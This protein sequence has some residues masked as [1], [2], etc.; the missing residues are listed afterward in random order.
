MRNSL[1]L[2][3]IIVCRNSIQLVTG[4]R[5]WTVDLWEICLEG[6]DWI[7]LFQD[8]DQWWAPVNTIM[9]LRVP[10]IEFF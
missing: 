3:T 5:S 6:V 7:H 1:G 10:C 2:Q 8:K 9:N 4:P